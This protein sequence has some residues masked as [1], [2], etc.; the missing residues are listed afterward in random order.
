[1]MLSVLAG[2][3]SSVFALTSMPLSESVFI[4][5]TWPFIAAK[6]RMVKPACGWEAEKRRRRM[7]GSSPEL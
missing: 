3:T 4:R 2:A 5:S 6:W 1:M 7:Q